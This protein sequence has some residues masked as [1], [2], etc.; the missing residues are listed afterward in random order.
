MCSNDIDPD[1]SEPD[2]ALEKKMPEIPA[3]LVR[4]ANRSIKG[5]RRNSGLLYQRIESALSRPHLIEEISPLAQTLSLNLKT[6][7]DPMWERIQSMSAHGQLPELVSSFGLVGTHISQQL[8][9]VTGRIDLSSSLWSAPSAFQNELERLLRIPLYRELP[10]I[11]RLNIIAGYSLPRIDLAHIASISRLAVPQLNALISSHNDFVS[12]YA[13][14]I[15]ASIPQAREWSRSAL[16]SVELAAESHYL[17][18]DILSQLSAEAEDEAIVQAKD[19]VRSA[20]VG[21]RSKRVVFLL[22]SLN[23]RLV[24]LLEGARERLGFN[25]PDT[26]RHVASS[27]RELL[28]QVLHSLAPDEEVLH[29]VSDPSL[30]HNDRPTRKARLLYIL[31][32]CEDAVPE[33]LLDSD[34][35]AALVLFD[36]L[37]RGQHAVE[38]GL[39]GKKLEAVIA[40]CEALLAQLL[41]AGECN[42]D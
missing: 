28:T 27:L 13:S 12:A 38:S 17:Y 22:S 9:A 30:L 36:V 34:V 24:T 14:F 5:F 16:L 33:E 23:P 1:Y 10:E 35:K 8:E 39:A 2:I 21:T 40:R 32:N 26:A 4:E 29:W 37:Q 19:D 6:Y 11:A 20:I 18:I 15:E 41:E 31:R 42:N 3:D 7:I 25:A